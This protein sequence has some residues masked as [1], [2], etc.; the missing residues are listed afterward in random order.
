MAL[1]VQAVPLVLELVVAVLVD[2]AA[3]L[4]VD[5]SDVVVLLVL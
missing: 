4:V 2:L 5:E 1:V 3:E